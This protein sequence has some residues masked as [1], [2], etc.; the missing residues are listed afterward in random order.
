MGSRRR[1]LASSSSDSQPESGSGVRSEDMHRVYQGV[2]RVRR[3]ARVSG[4]VSVVQVIDAELVQWT[5]PSSE[6]AG[7]PLL[8]AM[9]GVGSNERDL[10]GL[11][12]ALPAAWTMASL[13]APMPWG[14]G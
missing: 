2:R 3:T 7:T 14:Q 9:H 6:R 1:T 13:R 8:V 11:A 4:T 10:L 5:R 12:P